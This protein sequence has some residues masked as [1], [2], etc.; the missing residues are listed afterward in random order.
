MMMETRLGGM[1]A[2]TTWVTLL[3]SG[4]VPMDVYCFVIL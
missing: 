1:A 4:G 3:G 2:A